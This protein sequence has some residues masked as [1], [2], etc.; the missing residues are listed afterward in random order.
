VFRRGLIKDRTAA[1][2][3]LKMAR[4][5]VLSRFLTQRLAQVERQIARIDATMQALIASDTGLMERLS[6]LVSIPAHDCS[7]T[8]SPAKYF[9]IYLRRSQIFCDPIWSSTSEPR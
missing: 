7:D 2:T 8:S 9:L 4:Q 3:R 5:V 1:R 6:I